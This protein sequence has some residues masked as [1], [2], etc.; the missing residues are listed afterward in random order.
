[1]GNRCAN[2]YFIIDPADVEARVKEIYEL[3]RMKRSLRR[4][5]NGGRR[6]RLAAPRFR[7]NVKHFKRRY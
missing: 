5:K 2:N 6:R 3:E 4:G 7:K 1:M